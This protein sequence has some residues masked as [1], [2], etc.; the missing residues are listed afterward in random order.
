MPSGLL[1][2]RG[3]YDSLRKC[4]DDSSLF[5][6]IRHHET[7]FLL[8]KRRA[9]EKQLQAERSKPCAIKGQVKD[10]FDAGALGAVRSLVKLVFLVLI[11]PFHFSFFSLP[12]ILSTKL[13]LPLSAMVKKCCQTII[14][15]LVKLLGRVYGPV[16]KVFSKLLGLFRII[17]FRLKAPSMAALAVIKKGK[18]SAGVAVRPAVQMFKRG[19]TAASAAFQK[20][21]YRMKVV[22]VWA[23]LLWQ[24]G[25]LYVRSKK[26]FSR[27][28]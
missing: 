2:G 10:R 1:N 20:I 21:R 24:E 23:K 22:K 18:G 3:C 14:H 5:L 16:K 15:P 11:F 17:C 6:T 19:Q 27:D 26:P 13:L 9:K 28:R 8:E 7:P 4:E 12:P 25:L